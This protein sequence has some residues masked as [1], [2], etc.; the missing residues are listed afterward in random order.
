MKILVPFA[1]PFILGF[2]LRLGLGLCLGLGFL[3]TSCAQ[4]HFHAS[5]NSEKNLENN[6]KNNLSSYKLVK[7]TPEEK[8]KERLY[9]GL[10]NDRGEYHRLMKAL[11]I[12]QKNFERCLNFYNIDAQV[13]FYI[14]IKWQWEHGFYKTVSRESSQLSPDFLNCISDHFSQWIKDHENEYENKIENGDE[15]KNTFYLFTKSFSYPLNQITDVYKY[16]WLRQKQDNIKM[17]R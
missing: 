14:V 10:I 9:F 5:N 12:D 16:F 3:N 1:L 15:L 13:S 4:N 11:I 8:D 6:P 2:G 17:M 7:L